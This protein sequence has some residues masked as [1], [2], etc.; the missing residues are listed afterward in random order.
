MCIQTEVKSISF[1]DMFCF[2]KCFSFLHSFFANNSNSNNNNLFDNNK[3]NKT[4]FV[5]ICNDYPSHLTSYFK[6]IL[7]IIFI[8]TYDSV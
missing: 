1:Y 3:K 5:N 4:F 2:E 8:P 6:I 7:I